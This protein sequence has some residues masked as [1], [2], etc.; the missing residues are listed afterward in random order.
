MSRQ[1][2]TRDRLERRAVTL[3]RLSVCWN[4]VEGGAAVVAGLVAG[5]VTLTS[6]GIDSGIEVFS[7]ALVLVHLK[8]MIAGSEPDRAQERRLLRIIAATFYALAAY[9]V[10]DSSTTLVR[11]ARPETSAAG[12]AMAAAAL[13]VMPTLA[14]AKRRVG[15]ALGNPLVVA[16]AAETLL[17]AALA[18]CTLVGLVAWTTLGWWWVDPLAGYVI[19]YFALREGREAWAGELSCDD[20]D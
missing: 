10:I 15:R 18:V 6:W 11:A 1:P 2:P 20:D 16:D 19:G 14:F 3:A 17:C 7:A 8:A 12:M 5:S 9:V 13:V 4:A